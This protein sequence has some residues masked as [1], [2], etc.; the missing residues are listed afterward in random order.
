[1]KKKTV[2][3]KCPSKMSVSVSKVVKTDSITCTAFCFPTLHTVEVVLSNEAQQQW[4]RCIIMQVSE[5]LSLL[6]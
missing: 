3:L 2:E 1:M 5:M 4:A 6:L